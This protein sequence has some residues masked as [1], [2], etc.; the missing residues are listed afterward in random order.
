MTTEKPDYLT[1]EQWAQI[2]ESEAFLDDLDL[3]E[4]DA[5]SMEPSEIDDHDNPAA[6]VSDVKDIGADTA[7]TDAVTVDTEGVTDNV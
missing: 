1:E 4:Y 7:D 2:T 6:H 5:D 3:N